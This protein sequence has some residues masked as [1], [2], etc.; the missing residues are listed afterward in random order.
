[1]RAKHYHLLSIWPRRPMTL[2]TAAKT[3]K[4]DR[5]AN[6]FCVL[7]S[8]NIEL[9]QILTICLSLIRST[10]KRD[11]RR[12]RYVSCRE[13]LDA[14]PFE[15]RPQSA[16]RAHLH[17][18]PTAFKS[19]YSG[20]SDICQF[21]QLPNTQTHSVPRHFQLLWGQFN[22]PVLKSYHC[23]LT[24]SARCANLLSQGIN[25]ASHGD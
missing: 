13:K 14:Q 2:R 21:C 11:A 5:T 9:G 23:V 10:G 8:E 25:L 3:D 4:N 20:G 6:A 18:A 1:M 7:K 15:G 19:T 17:A 24:M 22:I 16:Y 12:T